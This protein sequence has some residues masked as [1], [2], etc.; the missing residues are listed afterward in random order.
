MLPTTLALPR[1]AA[2]DILVLHWQMSSPS[3]WSLLPQGTAAVV[4]WV[5]VS[6][7]SQKCT[8]GAYHVPSMAASAL[9]FTRTP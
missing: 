8:Q 3:S 1:K 2:L 5:W 4:Q 7:I 6:F 9:I